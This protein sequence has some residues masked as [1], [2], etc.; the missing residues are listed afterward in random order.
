ME[1]D[2]SK[3]DVVDS[4]VE[5]IKRAFGEDDNESRDSHDTEAST[6]NNPY[7]NTPGTGFAT[8]AI[9]TAAGTDLATEYGPDSPGRSTEPS[10]GEGDAGV[11][12]APVDPDMSADEGSGI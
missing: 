9:A 12:G 11:T 3:P 2:Q 8:G 4:I 5:N 6:T 7:A 10:L 1:H